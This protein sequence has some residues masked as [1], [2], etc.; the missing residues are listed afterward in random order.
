MKRPMFKRIEI[1]NS[2]QIFLPLSFLSHVTRDLYLILFNLFLPVLSR[3][4]KT[5]M[6]Y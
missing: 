4:V 2:E 6:I 3:Q 5:L 1:S